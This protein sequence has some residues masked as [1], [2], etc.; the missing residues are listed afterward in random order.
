MMSLPGSTITGDSNM[1]F[2]VFGL[3]LEKLALSSIGSILF[4][5]ALRL[6]FSLLTKM[7][8]YL[9]VSFIAILV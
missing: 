9:L 8:C 5:V 7:G 4:G 3:V 6:C 2:R 1:I